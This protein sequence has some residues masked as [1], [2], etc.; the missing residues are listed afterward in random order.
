MTEHRDTRELLELAAAEPDGLDRL[1]AGD[2]PEAAAVVGHL[3]GCP[4]CLEELARLRRAE[5]LLRPILAAAPD[6]ALRG[7]TLAYVGALGVPR[8]AGSAATPEPGPAVPTAALPTPAARP[9]P[10]RRGRTVS[11]PAR[12]ASLAAV[13]VIGLVAGAI[14]GGGAGRSGGNADPAVALDA[15]ARETAALTAAG[16][17]R[18]VALADASGAPLGSLVLSPSA[19]RIVVSAAGL[20]APPAGAEYRC[21]V[22]VEGRAGRSGRCGSRGT[23]PGG[24]ATS[25]CRPRSRPASSTACRSSRRGQRGPARSC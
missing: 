7:R 2:T 21:W 17:A 5:A 14:L 24:P 11:V 4:A 6:P 16:D 8:Q 3:A 20:D 15:I 23:S 22:E 12:A 10:A 18:S 25:R 9:G 13:L 19:G 1:E